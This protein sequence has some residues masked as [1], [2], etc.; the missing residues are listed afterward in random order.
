MPKTFTITLVVAVVVT[1]LLFLY[2]YNNGGKAKYC[3]TPSGPCVEATK[4]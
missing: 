4:V 1:V 2:V 3:A